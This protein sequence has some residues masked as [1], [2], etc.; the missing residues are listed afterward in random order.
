MTE[1]SAGSRDFTLLLVCTGGIRQY[2]K[3][4]LL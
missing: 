4:F 2:L 3:I 1:P